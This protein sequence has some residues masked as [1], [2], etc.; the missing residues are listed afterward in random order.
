MENLGAVV[1]ND[2]AI[3]L[4]TC[5]AEIALRVEDAC[6]RGLTK[7]TLDS[8]EYFILRALKPSI[9]LHKIQ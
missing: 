5:V 9:T 4:W 3:R 8:L 1:L 6:L 2:K 7:V